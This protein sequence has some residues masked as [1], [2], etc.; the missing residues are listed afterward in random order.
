[1]DKT[2]YQPGE[3]GEIHAFLNTGHYSGTISKSIRVYSNTAGSQVITLTV[4]VTI[5]TDL[6]PATTSLVFRNMKPGE[7]ATRQVYME[8]NM[9]EPLVLKG[10]TVKGNKKLTERFDIQVKRV[11]GEQ[12]KE[13]LEFR[14]TP[15]PDGPFMERASFT[16]DVETNSKKLP[17]LSFYL[18]ANLQKPIEIQP[19]SLF[20]YGLKAGTARVRRITLRS[21]TGRPITVVST[22]TRGPLPFTTE[23][24]KEDDTTIHVWLGIP[25]DAPQGVFN[26]V[27]NIQVND[28]KE[29]RTFSVPVRG[30]VIP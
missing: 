26:Q 24:V 18:I 21:N 17:H 6:K 3:E 7:T 22:E 27:F 30:S 19:I 10:F 25:A 5:V 14:V 15:K 11:V 8:N 28:G 12:N 2:A 20:M 4:K 16:V 9:G 29:T 23:I 13:Y 1:L